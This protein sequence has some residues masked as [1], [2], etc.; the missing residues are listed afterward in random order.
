MG[1]ANG[2]RITSGTD[3]YFRDINYP[4]GLTSSILSG[5]RNTWMDAK[6]ARPGTP[7]GDELS[8]RAKLQLEPQLERVT[9]DMKGQRKGC[10]GP[11]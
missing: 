5:V 8:Q 4:D 9:A 10:T 1:M 3:G 11:H 6:S 2:S 7:K